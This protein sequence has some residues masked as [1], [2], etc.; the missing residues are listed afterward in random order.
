MYWQIGMMCEIQ[1]LMKSI[2]AMQENELCIDVYLKQS[3][4]NKMF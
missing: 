4:W 3:L 1:M 2:S